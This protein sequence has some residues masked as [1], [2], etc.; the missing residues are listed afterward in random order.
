SDRVPARRRGGRPAVRAAVPRRGA[1]PGRGRM[2]PRRHRA[3]QPDLSPDEPAG[4]RLLALAPPAPADR[5]AAAAPRDGRRRLLC[6]H[7]CA[8]RR[9][10]G[11]PLPG[12]RPRW[13]RPLAG[14][15]DPSPRPLR[16]LLAAAARAL[17]A[18]ISRRLDVR[19]LAGD[20]A[21]LR[22]R[23]G[24]RPQRPR[25][26]LDRRRS[27]AS[28]A[29]LWPGRTLPPAWGAAGARAILAV[30]L[31]PWSLLGR[32][33]DATDPLDVFALGVAWV[34]QIAAALLLIRCASRSGS[35]LWVN[36]G[37][38]ALLA[39]ILTRYFDL[40]GDYL[41]GGLALAMTGVL[42]LVV[43]TILERSRRRALAGRERA[44]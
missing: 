11:S 40:F 9:G 22:R 4:E 33:Y 35:P 19:R 44:A 25:P 28:V 39:G 13:R 6:A 10:L 29:L 43:V 5:L 2:D 15:R 38:V 20:P 26:R 37:F 8:D 31:L 21:R 23:E 32:A 34:A 7:R 24:A 3:R 18:R 36:L 17:A 41:Q 42:I 1:R 16:R 14:A 12:R 27:G 30:S